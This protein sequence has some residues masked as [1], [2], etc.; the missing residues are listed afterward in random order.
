MKRV[1]VKKEGATGAYLHYQTNKSGIKD[2]RSKI[3][4]QRSDLGIVCAAVRHGQCL[5][6]R[7]ASVPAFFV[8]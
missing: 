5:F 1:Q 4:D 8:N 7:G 2:L 3:N 6:P